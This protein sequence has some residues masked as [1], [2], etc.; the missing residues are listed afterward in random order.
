MWSWLV[1]FP[2]FIQIFLSHFALLL[3]VFAVLQTDMCMG[4]NA[5][6]PFSQILPPFWLPQ[7]EQKFSDPALLGWAGAGPSLA[8][9]PGRSSCLQYR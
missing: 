5:S 4:C 9:A 3:K 7:Q 8:R 1:T 6:L 2:C